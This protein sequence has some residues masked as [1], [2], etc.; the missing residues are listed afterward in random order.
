MVIVLASLAGLLVGSF[1]N[2]CIYRLPR[3]L[4]VVRPRSFCPN[5]NEPIR[6]YDNIPLLSFLWLRGRCRH[7][8]RTIGWR[9]PAVE[10]LSGILWASSIAAF[11]L[12]FAFLRT[13]LF[14]SIL[15]C[16]LFTD[17]EYRLLP[18][19]LT[20]GGMIMGLILAVADPLKPGLV[21]LLLGLDSTRLGALA[22]AAIAALV[23]SSM[24]LLLGVAY[25]LLRG[26]EGLGL[27]DVKM[28]AMIGAFCGLERSIQI[29]A[30]GSV[31]GTIIGGAYM[32]IQKKDPQRYYLP[33]GSFLAAGGLVFLFWEIF[34]ALRHG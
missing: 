19:S 32:W 21:Q 8:R 24:L 2:V 4:S 1:L 3:G 7:C 26:R 30:L 16:L 31:L 29:L 9:Y 10:L 17:W 13:I 23:G 11:G 5:C 28:V 27:G 12:G 22:D 6:W 14:G 15:L 33:F 25:R 18:D 34:I 20:L